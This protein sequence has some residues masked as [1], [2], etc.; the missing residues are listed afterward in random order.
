MPVARR[1]KSR[2]PTDSL[3]EPMMPYPRCADEIGVLCQRSQS[4]LRLF[5]R[6]ESATLTNDLADTVKQ[7]RPTFHHTSTQDDHVRH[8][9]I[10]QI[11]QA[12]ANIVRFALN[13]SAR[14]LI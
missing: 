3:P 2:S 12:E 14:E 8:R 7:D 10:D 11:V 4:Q 13:L 6:N 1:D 9:K 5:K